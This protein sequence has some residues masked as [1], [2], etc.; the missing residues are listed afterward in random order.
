MPS[1]S[2]T[3][4]SAG[5][6]LPAFPLPG[7]SPRSPPNR[8]D[9]SSL[10]AYESPWG[11][12]RRMFRKTVRQ[13]IAKEFVRTRLVARAARS[14]CRGLDEAGRAGSCSPTC[15][16]ETAAAA[17]VRARGRGAGG[18]RPGGVHFGSAIQ[19]TVAQYILGYGSEEQKRQLDPAPG[20]RRKR[21]RDRD[22]RARR[23]LRPSGHQTAPGATASTTSSRLE[24]LINTA[25]RRP[26]LLAAK[27]NPKAIGM[28]PF[29][30]IMLETKTF[31]G[32]AS[33]RAGKGRHAR[34]G[35]GR[36]FLRRRAR[37]AQPIG[38]VE[39]RGFAR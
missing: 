38:G 27:T 4:P 34:P 20:A 35:Y 11:T 31:R 24:D 21:R 25:Q 29:R 1:R 2:S 5:W 19:S 32:T 16:S 36:A 30:S 8:I 26:G 13:F 15:R 39:G 33:P 23:G 22:E 12:T 14:R 3:S 17:H 10:T 18:A 28:R 6:R 7:S 9:A 37:A